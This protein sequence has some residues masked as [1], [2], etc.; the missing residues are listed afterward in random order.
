MTLTYELDLD[1][2]KMNHRAKYLKL[3]SEDTDTQTNTQTHTHTHA[4]SRQTALHGK[5]YDIPR[6][7]LVWC[8]SSL[9]RPWAC[10]WIN[11][12]SLW[13]MASATSDL[14]LPSQSQDIAA[15]ATGTKLYFLVSV[16]D[17][18][19]CVWTLHERSVGN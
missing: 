11:H 14:R 5:E 16:D 2:V 8:S 6:R 4:H 7:V 9:L 15:P 19:T 18:G 1:R 17:R 13:R 10:R 3:L 12:S